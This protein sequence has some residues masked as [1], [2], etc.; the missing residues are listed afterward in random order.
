MHTLTLT[1]EQ[2]QLAIAAM[3]ICMPT[4]GGSPMYR[5]LGAIGRQTDIDADPE[6]LARV[7][8][9]ALQEAVAQDIVAWVD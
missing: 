1:T 3:T 6:L 9:D 4:G 7:G 5:A 2:L 8:R